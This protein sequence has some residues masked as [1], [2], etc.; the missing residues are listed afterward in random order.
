MTKLKYTFKTDV[1]FKILFTKNP[2]L[3]KQLVSDLLD[4]KPESIRQF[5]ITTPEMPAESIKEKFCRLD[6]NMLVDGQRVNLEI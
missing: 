6:I 4:I 2:D 5:V 1:L 3:L